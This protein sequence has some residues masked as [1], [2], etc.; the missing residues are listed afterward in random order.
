MV[1][2]A[3]LVI[4]GATSGFLAEPAPPGRESLVGFFHSFAL[5]GFGEELIFRYLLL[6]APSSAC[7]S[8]V[9]PET[10]KQIHVW[11][12]VSYAS[13]SLLAFM[14]YHVDLFH[15]QDIFRDARFL[16]CA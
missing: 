16:V 8:D 3:L 2:F 4:I 6:P 9:C 11:A 1:C 15:M 14:V 13:L 12:F 10:S 7:F 5:V